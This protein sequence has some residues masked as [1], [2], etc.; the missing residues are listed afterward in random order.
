MSKPMKTPHK[1]KLIVETHLITVSYSL[2][3]TF[4]NLRDQ[5]ENK[6]IVKPVRNTHNDFIKLIMSSRKAESIRVI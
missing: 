1:I 5:K 4:N 6:K 3:K 2:A